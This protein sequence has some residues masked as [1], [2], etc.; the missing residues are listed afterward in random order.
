M[1]PGSSSSSSAF[2]SNDFY[3]NDRS[4]F[5]DGVEHQYHDLDLPA[6]NSRIPLRPPFLAASDFQQ[7]WRYIIP[8]EVKPD[9]S[10]GPLAISLFGV[11]RQRRV[12]VSRLQ[13]IL[14]STSLAMTF[15]TVHRRR[16]SS[17][18][19]KWYRFCLQQLLMGRAFTHVAYADLAVHREQ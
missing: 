12:R 13:Q 2:S 8:E 17:R 7:E 6:E 3:A 5:I 14:L 4:V 19:L 1:A 11:E 18:N 9:C 10:P 16:S 15:P